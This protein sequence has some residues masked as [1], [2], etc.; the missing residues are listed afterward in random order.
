MAV[1][2]AVVAVDWGFQ[3]ACPRERRIGRE[4]DGFDGE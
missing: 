3:S 1:E 4:F 2:H